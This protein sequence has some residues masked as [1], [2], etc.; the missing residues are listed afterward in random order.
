MGLCRFVSNSA[1]PRAFSAI[2][3]HL[4]LAGVVRERYRTVGVSPDMPRW[5]EWREPGPTKSA[6]NEFH[7]LPMYLSRP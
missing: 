2:P 3:C 1:F 5:D 7:A 4:E 6:R